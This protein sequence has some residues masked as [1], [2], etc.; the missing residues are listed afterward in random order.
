MK[1]ALS[2]ILS[3][4]LVLLMFGGC[5]KV[6]PLHTVDLSIMPTNEY[7]EI[8]VAEVESYTVKF[9]FPEDGYLKLLNCD[10]TEYEN[11]DWE[12]WP[13]FYV[14]FKNSKGRVL[15]ENIATSGGYCENYRFEK[16]EITAE[17]RIEN[18]L[19]GMKMLALSWAY[20]PD[21]DEPIPVKFDE[22]AAAARKNADGLSL[23]SFRVG[24]PCVF[25]FAPTEACIYEGDCN[26]WIEN[27]NG[28]NI[29][30]EL[31]IHGTEWGTRK[32][33]LPAGDYI[34]K[35]KDIDSVA[36]CKIRTER[37]VEDAFME[38]A[39]DLTAPVTLG[40]TANEYRE[41]TIHFNTADGEKLIIKPYGTG[42][43]YDSEHTVDVVIK[44]AQGNIVATSEEEC[45]PWFGT[46]VFEFEGHSGEYTAT[47]ST[48]SNCVV[49]VEI[50]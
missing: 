11:W 2:L 44:D 12:V 34:I 49:D 26:F 40:F 47:I 35:V 14:T 6:E 45:D 5:A 31:S 33:F 15:Y 41:N 3:F 7:L 18:K 17:I 29:T 39:D 8:D 13:E 42:N 27:L 32:A 50:E 9:I 20:A 46:Y 21:T 23:F 30:G 48:Q 19:E 1:R 28:E 24:S 10:I 36:S 38:E 22:E 25:S 16:G 43:F 37:T 4:T